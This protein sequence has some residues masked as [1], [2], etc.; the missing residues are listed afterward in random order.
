MAA[1]YLDF[2]RH[3]IRICFENAIA[4]PFS[5]VHE[6]HYF[7]L[8]YVMDAG[9][10]ASSKGDPHLNFTYYYIYCVGKEFLEQYQ[11]FVPLQF[12]ESEFRRCT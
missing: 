8:P 6:L 12:S 7:V 3:L 5:A 1:L 10:S 9:F 2:F 4:D 11:H